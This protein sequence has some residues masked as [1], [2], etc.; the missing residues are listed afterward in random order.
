MDDGDGNGV[1]EMMAGLPGEVILHTIYN[2]SAGCVGCGTVM[3]PVTAMY[4][5][6]LCPSCRNGQATRRVEKRLI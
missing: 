4:G 5:G 3:N 1:I 2:G 6:S